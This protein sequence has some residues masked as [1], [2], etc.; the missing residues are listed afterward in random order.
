M[1]ILQIPVPYTPRFKGKNPQLP[2]CAKAQEK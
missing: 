2:G 1:E